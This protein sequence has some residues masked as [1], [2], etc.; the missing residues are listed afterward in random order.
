MMWAWN[1]DGGFLRN[2]G[3]YD[4][5]GSVIIF[6]TGALAGLIGTIVIGPR[7]GKFMPK[8]IVDRII[9]GGKDQ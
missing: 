4:R 1:L 6:N 8:K 7:Y 5:G 3:Y 2:L 9:A